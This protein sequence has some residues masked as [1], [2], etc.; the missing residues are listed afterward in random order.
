MLSL[1]VMDAKMLATQADAHF[2]IAKNHAFDFVEHPLSYFDN[3][4]DM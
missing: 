3:V 2:D 1:E 4:D